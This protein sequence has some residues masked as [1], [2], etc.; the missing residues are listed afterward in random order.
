M[1]EH[2]DR[3][4][5]SPADPEA[6]G[7][8]MGAFRATFLL[9]FERT[10]DRDA[11]ESFGRLLSRGVRDLG[12]R[13]CQQTESRESPTARS[14]EAVVLDLRHLVGFLARVYS[15]TR[16]VE[17]DPEE[18]RLREGLQEIARDLQRIALRIERRIEGRIESSERNRQASS[19]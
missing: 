7:T 19:E 9:S 3:A 16:A 11:I 15:D 2:L 10:A 8:D 6:Q 14:L 5:R 13:R 12:L 4:L 17:W 1:N 18:G